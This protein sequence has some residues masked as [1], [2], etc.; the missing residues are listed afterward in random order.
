MSRRGTPTHIYSDN[1]TNF[2]GADRILRESL[3]AWNQ[4]Q[5]HHELFQRNVNWNFN[6][7]AAS[8]MGGCWER[9]IR[10]TRRILSTIL[11]NQLVS[12]D[13]LLTIM[14]EIE[15][16]LNSRPLIPLSFDSSDSEPLTPNHLLMTKGN[17]NLPPGLFDKRDCYV[18]RR[19]A[20]V[21]YIAN[22]FWIRWVREY[23]PYLNSRQKWFTDT[24]NFK[25]DDLVLLL[26]DSQPRSRWS[27]RR[28]VEVYPDSK[29]KVK[30]VMVKTSRS[31]VKRPITKI[32]LVERAN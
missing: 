5:I 23:M 20:Q 8:H 16:I 29:G 14:V 19:W 32:C 26:E 28:V 11:S 12:D 13:V 25:V 6:P 2:V 15:G 17:I 30:I 21:Q 10:S 24:S 31:L 4:A 7:P 3:K 9:L 1:G 18:R 22:Q 27:N